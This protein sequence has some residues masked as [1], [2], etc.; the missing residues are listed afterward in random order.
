MGPI[1]IGFRGVGISLIFV[2]L[3]GISSLALGLKLEKDILWGTVRT[4]AQLYIMGYILQYI[5]RLF[6]PWP[7]LALYTVM[8]VFAVNI[9]AGRV[10]NKEVAYIIPTFFTMLLTY[11]LITIFL[12]AIVIQ[13]NPWYN[14]SYFIPLGG[15]VIGNSM[16]AIAI[17][18]ERLFGDLKKSYAEIELYLSL[19][20]DYKEAS[21]SI[22][23]QSIKAGMI[24][25]INSMMGVGIVFLP[26]MMSGQIIAGA[27][28][29]IAVP[30]QIMIM[31]MLVGSTTLGSILVAFLVRRL[32]FS[33]DHR[34]LLKGSE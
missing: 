18:L 23:G 11:T 30:Y 15:M 10:K 33:E 5:F 12:T 28:P 4:I 32:C 22:L 13:I 26:G 17:T 27:D 2:F 31:L 24:P 6:L 16:N 8:I 20:A 9:I 14:P 21:A 34:L 25:S 29:M 19:G 1:D 7:I 3:A